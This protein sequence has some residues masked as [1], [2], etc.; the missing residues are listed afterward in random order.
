VSSV[1]AIVFALSFL[2]IVHETGHYLAA[3]AFGMRVK[4]YSIGIG[5]PI[6]K[7]QP[8]G[9]PTVF[10]LA[11]IPIL[12]FV[13]IDGMNP[14]DES[15]KNDRASF[16]NASVFARIVTIFAGSAFNYIAASLLLFGIYVAYGA[17]T[18]L[19]AIVDTVVAGS[20]AEVGGVRSG[21]R[22]VEIA[23][24]PIHTFAE[25]QRETQ[26]SEG[27]TLEYVVERQGERVTLSIT[28]RLEEQAYR[29][30]IR[31]LAE[32]EPVD[33]GTAAFMAVE[34]P[35]LYSIENL[36]MLAAKLKVGDTSDAHGIIGMAVGVS[37][38]VEE[39]MRSYLLTLAGLSVAL[40]L[41]NLFPFPALDGGRLTFLM[42]ELITR[43]RPNE[44]IEVAIHGVGFLV[45]LG[46]IV[47][48]N[49]RDIL[50][51]ISRT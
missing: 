13:E 33:L 30:G 24:T 26:A 11:A 40:G 36:K 42:Y 25:L 45:L 51:F 18:P 48:V 41:F 31:V 2:M 16:Q 14:F 46:L 17:Q 1:F 7:F 29:I 20:A 22:I 34:R 39:G 19:H 49:F 35:I 32:F 27:R 4:R 37:D 9:S 43:R 44:K 23:G 6:A 10:Q 38:A 15:A 3:R 21:D 8:K 5:P 50:Q 28:P 12:A 47:A